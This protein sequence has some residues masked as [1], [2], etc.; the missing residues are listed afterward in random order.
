[1]GTGV[2]LVLS[3]EPLEQIF[4]PA[5]PG[6]LYLMVSLTWL[7]LS[8]FRPKSSTMSTESYVLAF[9][10]IKTPE[11]RFDLAI[12][13]SR[14]SEGLSW[15]IFV[16]LVYSLLHT[17]FQLQDHRQIDY[18]EEN[19]QIFTIYAHGGHVGHV[20]KTI[21]KNIFWRLYMK[22]DYNRSNGFREEIC[23]KL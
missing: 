18:R 5:N 23:L 21:W 6:G 7:H 2:I 11:S 4:V 15:T 16:V 12:E 10:H 1:M 3:H 13:R 8:N 22:Y 19:L 14:S 9:S 20:I 17:M